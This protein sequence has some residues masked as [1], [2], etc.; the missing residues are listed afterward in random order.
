METSPS[1]DMLWTPSNTSTTEVLT[2]PASTSSLH[3]FLEYQDN[4]VLVEHYNYTGKLQRD[5]YR[6]GLKPEG[7]AFL[8]VCLL[9]VLENAVV[10]LSIWR[11]KKFHLPMYYLLG[12]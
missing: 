10:L 6:Q 7:I 8:V 1:A 3:F 11:N 4:A 2:T 12:T 5:R 9:I